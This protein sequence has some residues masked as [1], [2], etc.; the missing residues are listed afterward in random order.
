MQKFQTLF[1]ASYTNINT[2]NI[3]IAFELVGERIALPKKKRATNVRPY[4]YKL[5]IYTCRGWALLLPLINKTISP[6]VILN[7]CEESLMSSP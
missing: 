2:F 4:D 1:C 3:K 6:R 5:T 7:E